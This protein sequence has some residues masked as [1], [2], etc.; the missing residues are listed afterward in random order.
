MMQSVDCNTDNDVYQADN[1]GPKMHP[2]PNN[3]LNASE[4]YS[5]VT[6]DKPT[7]TSIPMGQKNNCYM[8][9]DNS[10]NV[11]RKKSNKKSQFSDDLESWNSDSGTTV[12]THYVISHDFKCAYMKNGLYCFPKK[13]N[14][15]RTFIPISPQP[16]ESDV[17]TLH[18]YYTT[19]KRQPDFKKRV[20]WFSNPGNQ[21]LS[22]R[23]I[24]EY[25]SVVKQMDSS[26]GNSKKDNGPYNRTHPDVLQHAAQE[27]KTKKPRQ[28]YKEMVLKDEANA[29]RDLQQLRDL[30]Y[31]TEGKSATSNGNNVADDILNVLSMVKDHPFIQKVEQSKNNVPSIILYSYEQMT[32]FKKIIGTSKEPRVGIIMTL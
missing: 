17:V 32:D 10:T 8:L 11:E 19:L 28:V 31:R 15:K 18:K 12:N 23:A 26:H 2:L 1:D 29:P 3:V 27:L 22:T 13:V 5:I 25:I 6:S 20:T 4:L 21:D 24:V 14:N 30:K 9:L 7:F 16:A